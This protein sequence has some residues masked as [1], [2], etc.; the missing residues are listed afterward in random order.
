MAQLVWGTVGERF[1]ETGVDRGVLY[2]KYTPG[3]AWSGL[4]SVDES[5]EG[6][7]V[8][9]FHFD[10]IKYL[11]FVAS[12]DFQATVEA[13]S[14]PAEFSVSDGHKALSPGLFATQQPRLT[15]GMSY[16]TLIGNDIDGVDYG[17]K[18]HLVYNATAGPS[19]NKRQTMSGSVSPEVKQWTIYTVPPLSLTYKPTAH[20]VVDSTLASP[21][22]LSTL[23][24]TLYGVYG[25]PELPTQAEIIS[26]FA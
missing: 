22:K 1:Y 19:S 8:E 9:P 16:R 24:N 4:I 12:E 6:G 18:L 15:F 20:I 17:Y 23:E 25:D 3:V 2:P 7:D 14:A 5:S 21:S 10:G 13:F 26:M 11:D